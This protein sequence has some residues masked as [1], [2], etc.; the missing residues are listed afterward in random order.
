M[1]FALK[2]ENELPYLKLVKEP[3]L[4]VLPGGKAEAKPLA[5]I[6]PFDTK[7]Q[8]PLASCNYKKAITSRSIDHQ[9]IGFSVQGT[10]ITTYTHNKLNQLSKATQTGKREAGKQKQGKKQGTF[11]DSLIY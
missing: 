7:H 3:M 2:Q 5:E 9:F 6:I 4:K 10:S 1:G 11:I 8:Q